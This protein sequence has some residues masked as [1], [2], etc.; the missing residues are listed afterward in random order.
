[1]KQYTITSNDA[2]Q[3]LDKFLKKLLP[4][5]SLSYIYKLSRKGNIKVITLDQLSLNSLPLQGKEATKM[6]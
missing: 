6:K 5:A 3:R 1:M 4:N 2:D